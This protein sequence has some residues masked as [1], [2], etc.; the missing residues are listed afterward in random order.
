MKYYIGAD[1]GT[2]ALKLLLCDEKKR[3]VKTVTREYPV[4]YPRSGWSEQSPELWWNAF[5]GGL[6]ELVDGID[7]FDVA[8]L[9][10]AGQMHGLVALDENDKVI[11]PAILW[12]DG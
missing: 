5:A 1:L 3:I 2:S 7:G 4:S 10:V 8:A 6:G 11:R 12:N 9:A